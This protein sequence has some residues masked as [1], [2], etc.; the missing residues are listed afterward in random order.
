MSISLI[1]F[2]KIYYFLLDF[3]ITKEAPEAFEESEEKHD[4]NF[5]EDKHKLP[6]ASLSYYDLYIYLQ[7]CR[8]KNP[9]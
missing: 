9:L 8:G 1:N 3:D 7:K 4:G 6:Y 5:K 2:L